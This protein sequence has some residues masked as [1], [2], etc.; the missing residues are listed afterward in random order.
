MGFAIYMTVA[1]RD[2]IQDDARSI[3]SFLDGKWKKKTLEEI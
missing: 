1:Q 3:F 2:R